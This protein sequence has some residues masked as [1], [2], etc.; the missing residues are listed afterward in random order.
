MGRCFEFGSGNAEVG[1][2]RRGKKR[3]AHDTRCTARTEGDKKK[4]GGKL[5]RWEGVSNSEVGMRPPAHRGYAYAPVGSGKLLKVA[6]DKSFDPE[7]FDPELTTEGLTTEG[8]PSTC[9]GPELVE[10]QASQ[11]GKGKC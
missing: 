7:L 8:L 3:R 2:K 5:R 11:R 1:N 10:R 6:F 9:S 4:E